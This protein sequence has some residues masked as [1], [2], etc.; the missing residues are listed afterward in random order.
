[1]SSGSNTSEKLGKL[2]AH[3]EIV[4]DTVAVV[5]IELKTMNNI[6]YLNTKQ[7]EIH[8][9]GVR[10]AR[11]QNE[12]LRKEFNSRIIPMEDN[13]KFIYK[14]GKLIACIITLPPF[15]YY[16]SQCIHIFKG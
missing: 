6:L 2:E 3:L 7:L 9:E 4:L 15:I 5:Q 12:L 13:F 11:E 10:L 14:F 1:M 16:V 8:I